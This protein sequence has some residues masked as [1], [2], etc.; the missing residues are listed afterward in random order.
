MAQRVF[1]SGLLTYNHFEYSPESTNAKKLLFTTFSHAGT[2]KE[3]TKLCSFT[4][5]IQLVQQEKFNL[6]RGIPDIQKQLV[7]RKSD[8]FH[9]FRRLTS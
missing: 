1:V 7:Q 9:E 3:G 8:F 2:Q 6:S 5:I 4:V